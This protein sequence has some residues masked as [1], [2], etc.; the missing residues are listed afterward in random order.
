MNKRHYYYNGMVVVPVS[1]DTFSV[2]SRPHVLVRVVKM[3]E[4]APEGAYI[5]AEYML[6]PTQLEPLAQDMFAVGEPVESIHG[7]FRGVVTAYEHEQNRVVCV[8]DKQSGA[9]D[10]RRFAYAV[11]DLVKLDKKFQFKRG[12]KY[13]IN[14]CE[15]V[16]AMQHPDEVDLFVLYNE[17]GSICMTVN[18]EEALDR[19]FKAYGV[20]AIKEL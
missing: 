14:G 17:N 19:L 18:R 3:Y 11:R 6:C 4:K 10:R 12:R 16:W 20:S 5:G 2:D 9:N 1:V 8:S 15:K 13:L 7:G